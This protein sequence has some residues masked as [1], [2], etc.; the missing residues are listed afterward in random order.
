MLVQGVSG[1]PNSLGYFGFSYYDQNREVLKALAVDA[2]DG[3]VE[4]TKETIQSGEYPLSRHPPKR[5][6]RSPAPGAPS[7]CCRSAP[8]SERFVVWD[9]HRDEG[10]H[11][12]RRSTP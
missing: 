7:G 9:L 3:P 2:G 10:P 8:R 1:D 5:L 12:T 6:A 4:P 11:R